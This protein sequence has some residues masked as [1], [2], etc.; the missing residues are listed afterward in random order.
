M[1]DDFLLLVQA[2]NAGGEYRHAMEAQ[3]MV[4]ALNKFEDDH[5]TTEAAWPPVADPEGGL[6]WV[7]RS[8]PD[9]AADAP[10]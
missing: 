10:A 8:E 2:L 7:N 1:R 5:Y 4:I 9:A 3:A 6:M